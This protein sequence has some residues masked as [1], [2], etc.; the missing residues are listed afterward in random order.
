VAQRLFC[1][2]FISNVLHH[3]D[4]QRRGTTLQQRQTQTSPDDRAVSSKIT[5]LQLVV[6]Y[7]AGSQLLKER[8]VLLSILRRR[9]IDTMFAPQFV[10]SETEH[11]AKGG[12]H[13]ERLPV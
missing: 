1:R 3:R 10:L 12:I 2:P 8:P 9:K 11:R 5:L 13:E 6:I 4:Y 7:R